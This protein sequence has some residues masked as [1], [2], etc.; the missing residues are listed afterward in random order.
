MGDQF[1]IAEKIAQEL[2][3]RIADA[4]RRVHCY[5]TCCQDRES[6]HDVLCAKANQEKGM[7]NELAYSLGLSEQ[8]QEILDRQEFL[9]VEKER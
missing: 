3:N 6:A 8:V 5:T 7:I 2:A 9:A 1:D 4:N